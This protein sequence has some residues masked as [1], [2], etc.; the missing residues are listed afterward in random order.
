M[1]IFVWTAAA[2]VLAAGLARAEPPRVVA[3]IAPVHSLVAR[4]MQGAGAPALLLPPGA[5]PHAHAL[6]P[7]DAQALAE[8]DLVVW[9]GPQLTPW[10]EKPIAALARGRVVRLAEVPALVRLAPR[11][12][13]LFGAHDH[14]HGDDHD[15]GHD[16][17][18]APD[19][20]A[21]VDPHFWLDPVNAKYWL[22][23]IAAA[24]S[25]ADPAGAALYQ[26]NAAAALDE[27]DALGA[28]IAAR[29][30]PLGG[31][32][33]VVFHDAY[34][35]FEAR[36]GVEALAALSLGD[37]VE[38]GAARVAAV[39]DVIRELGALCVFTEPQ[40]PPRLAQVLVEGSAARIG[41]LDPIGTGL[42][43]GPG[44]YPALLLGLADSLAACLGG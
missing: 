5:S 23:E 37:A 9:V 16:A 43:P 25:A 26:A 19:R 12:G 44:L 18:G 21:A 29:L 22:A 7:A 30:V 36:F 35:Y 20:A 28:A 40:F 42:E 4:V 15:H 17:A 33:F 3:D 39:R 8:A 1:R 34:H 38:P 32:P 6:R 2:L 13:V 41:T 31:R 10:A 14:A 24:L 27:I 11:Q